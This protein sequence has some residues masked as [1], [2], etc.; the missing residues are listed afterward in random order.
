MTVIFTGVGDCATYQGD[1]APGAGILYPA[2]IYTFAFSTASDVKRPE[3]YRNGIRV[4]E[5]S[6]SSDLEFT[7]TLATQITTFEQMA[8]SLN[9][10][11]KTFTDQA[12]P[13]C[14]RY[15][16]PATAPYT[17]AIPELAA[18]YLDTVLVSLDFQSSAGHA[19]PLS[20]SAAPPDDR[21]FTATAGLLTFNAAQAGGVITVVFLQ[22]LGSVRGLGGPGNKE[23][24]G[25][26]EFVGNLFDTSTQSLDGGRIWFKSLTI[27]PE[28]K[29]EFSGDILTLE[30]SLS[31]S[32][33]AGWSDPWF[34]L[35]GHTIGP[36]VL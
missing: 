18:P 29:L 12:F 11:P 15:Q 9:S 22:M 36:V 3:V 28:P 2:P 19:G 26:L 17:I 7:L 8:F 4:K 21:E 6:F 5:G 10:K 31:A 13:W 25:Q 14:K 20:P 30:T 23:G 24:L 34:I 33:P 16:I 1:A 32:V 35:D 27:N